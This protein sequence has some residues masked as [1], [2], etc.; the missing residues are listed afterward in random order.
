MSSTAGEAAPANTVEQTL[1]CAQAA[2]QAKRFGEAAG[3]CNDILATRPDLAPAL[4]LLGMVAAHT[5]EIDRVISLLERAV[6][7]QAGVAA[8]HATSARCIAWFANCRMP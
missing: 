4:A 1:A 6:A 5:G 8:W 7:R 2:A 3:I